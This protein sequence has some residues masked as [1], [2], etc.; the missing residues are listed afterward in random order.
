MDSVNIVNLKIEK[1]KA[2]LRYRRIT[3]L[4]R[5]VEFFV[6][7]LMISRISFQFPCSFKFSSEFFRPLFSPQFVFVIGNAIVVILV[8]KSGRLC[9]G[10][11]VTTDFCEDYLEN[12]VKNHI[13]H[14]IESENQKKEDK[15]I[16]DNVNYGERRT[17]E[18]T[19]S[20]N[21]NRV[22]GQKEKMKRQL[23]RTM[24]E[25]RRKSTSA[26]VG[27]SP[28]DKMSNEEFRRTVE[29]FIA[30]QQKSLREEEFSAIVSS[31]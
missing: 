9:S 21:L 11:R 4:F 20:E 30:R 10:N 6:L 2:N 7:L 25:G 14:E 18:R 12:S 17:I 19:Y 23:R 1:T 3:A 13:V 29:D 27:S 28:A 16:E 24:T 5:V 31:Y 26:A 8:V 15:I 22:G